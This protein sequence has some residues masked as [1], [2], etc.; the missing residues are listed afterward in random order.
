MAYLEA[1]PCDYL[2]FTAE[3]GRADLKATLRLT[4]KSPVSTAFKVK[5]TAHKQYSVQPNKGFL[6]PN[7]SITVSI[8]TVA[9]IDIE[10]SHKFQILAVAHKSAAEPVPEDVWKTGK[11]QN[12]VLAAKSGGQLMEFASIRSNSMM[13]NQTMVRESVGEVDSEDSLRAECEGLKKS[14]EDLKLKVRVMSNGMAARHSAD[15]GKK[16]RTGYGNGH[17]AVCFVLGLLTSL[18]LS[19]QGAF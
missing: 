1:V 4:N 7:A 14:V 19:Y 15:T 10:A 17:V 2:T 11:V 16:K 18:V 9:K 12:L 5:T 8:T 13:T 3:E 6:T